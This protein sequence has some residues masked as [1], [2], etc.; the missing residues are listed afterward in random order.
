VKTRLLFVGTAGRSRSPIVAGLAQ[1]LAGEIA[2]V[3]YAAISP[4]QVH[5]LAL[6]VMAER[7]ILTVAAQPESL[8]SPSEN[9]DY[10]FLLG[11]DAVNHPRFTGDGN[12]ENRGRSAALERINWPCVDPLEQ[13]G[14]EAVHLS[15]LRIFRDEMERKLTA[16]LAGHNLLAPSGAALQRVW[17]EL[18]RYEHSLFAWEAVP[19]GEGV[20]M[21][22]RFKPPAA[23]PEG[24]AFQLRPRELESRQFPWLFQKQLYD[25]LHDY[26]IELFSRNPQQDES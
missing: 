15:R 2:I 11:D 10:I 13:D 9:C 6:H 12:A 26:V 3:E 20:E 14:D 4:G 1:A 17:R 22:I 18:A 25:C 5:P 16:W 23:P 24:Y 8:A 19:A 7:G 21:R